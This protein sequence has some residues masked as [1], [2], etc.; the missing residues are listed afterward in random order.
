VHELADHALHQLSD[1]TLVHERGL[2]IKLGELG[3][4]VGPQVLV[5]KAAHDLVVAIEARHH[6]ELLEQLRRLRQRVETARM[7]AAWHQKVP[8]ALGR[9]PG[10]HGRFDIEKTVA[11]EEAV[12]EAGHPG[13]GDQ[14][15]L[16]RR[17]A[18]I[19]VAMT[20]AHVLANVVLVELE[21]RRLGRIEHFYVMG[22][23]LDLARAEVFVGGPLRPATHPATDP[24]HPLGPGTVGGGEGLL[25][26]RVEHHLQATL[27]VA[28]IN[29]D[30]TPVVP[31]PV[32][33]AAD[34]YILIEQGLGDIAAV[35][36]AHR[37]QTAIN[38][39]F[40]PA[41]VKRWGRGR[42]AVP[43][44][45]QGAKLLFGAAPRGFT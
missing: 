42:Q 43:T 38:G 26:I 12:H 17:A 21:R 11:V 31:P 9:R 41:N 23:H 24:Q 30:D 8:G 34:F 36:G 28:Q 25:T 32:H 44:G 22:E 40:R 35:V 7:Q 1:L 2:D 19:H 13:A 27:A 37:D 16:H 39:S 5:P 6:Q 14:V 10:E 15:L 4:A 3:L 45:L 29:E 18:Q 33:P 20:Q